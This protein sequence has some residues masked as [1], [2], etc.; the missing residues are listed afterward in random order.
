MSFYFSGEGGVRGRKS[1]REEAVSPFGLNLRS[2]QLSH[3][4]EF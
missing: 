1:G 2:A 3:L 4:I